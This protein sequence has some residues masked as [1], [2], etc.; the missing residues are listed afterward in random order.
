GGGGGEGGGGG[1]GGGGGRGGGGAQVGLVDQGGALEGR[2]RPLLGHPR[3]GEPAQLVVDE[4]EQV[5]GGLAVTGRRGVQESR[6]LGHAA[7]V[8]VKDD[9]GRRK[10]PRALRAGPSPDAYGQRTGKGRVEHRQ[11]PVTAGGAVLPG[12]STGNGVGGGPPARGG[13]RRR[14]LGLGPSLPPT[15]GRLR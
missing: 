9:R 15:G 13:V 12:S 2:P 1:G 8:T 4:R 6:H 3:R 11:Q 7:S 14:V 10:A 5:G